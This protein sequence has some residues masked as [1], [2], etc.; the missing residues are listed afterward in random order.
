MRLSTLIILLLISITNNELTAQ[1]AAKNLEK[2]WNYRARLLGEKG[3]GGF[4]DVGLGSGK[5]L[6]ASERNPYTDCQHDWY[7]NDKNCVTRKG[8]GRL[9]WG[10]ATAYHGFYMAILALE[11]ANLERDNQPTTAV[12]EEL[13]FALEA[14]ERLD[15]MAEVVVGVPGK[16]DGFFIRDD[17][18]GNFYEKEDA[19]DNRR[20]S[21]G[22][23]VFDCVS[24]AM[25]CDTPSAEKGSFI[26][27]DQVICLF[28]G[29]ATIQQLIPEKRYRKDLP[30]FGEKARINVHRIA[31]Y[32][33][34]NKWKLRD[35]K[36]NAIPD[37]W[38]GNA[39]SLSYPISSIANFLTQQKYEKNYR[40]KG[41]LW[42]GKPIYDLL[43]LSLSFQHNTNI[44]LA[45]VSM[46][47]L[48]QSSYKV[49][50]RRG[51]KYDVI[52]YP[53]MR[54]VLFDQ[55]LYKKIKRSDFDSLLNEAPYDGPCFGTPDC[56]APDGWKSYN[57]WVH[58]HFK[59]GNPYNVHSET[60]GLDYMILYNLYHY[61]YHDKQLP[62]YKKPQH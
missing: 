58:P 18:A 34:S 16:K 21:K 57:R 9:H 62:A 59:N 47:L 33:M 55:A 28:L 30:T 5:S 45:M 8:K 12:A 20:F 3:Q 4:I 6:A 49:L 54:S 39:I 10:D 14:F 23:N 1:T 40:K 32:M 48:P 27:Q 7:L 61:Y 11:Y 50:G 36:G 24:S 43:Q 53:L 37:Q 2:Y 35:P 19:P 15:S 38:G 52:L 56:T 17:V 41:A 46:T 60:P 26:S 44:V 31:N 29:F 25:S 51:I 13:W 42:L 22:T